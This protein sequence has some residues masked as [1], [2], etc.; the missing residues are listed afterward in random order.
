[1]RS[2]LAMTAQRLAKRMLGIPA[3]LMTAMFLVAAPAAAAPT[4]TMAAASASDAF[5]IVAPD[6]GQQDRTALGEAD[7]NFRQ[8]FA[9]WGGATPQSGQAQV[10]IPSLK[11]VDMMRFTSR[12]G[13][14]TD[15]FQG[16]RANHKGLDIAG[17]IGTPIHATAD[18]IVGRAQWVNGYGKFVEINHGGEIQTRYGHM[19]A[20]NVTPNQRV[21]KGDII[22]Y[23]GSTGRSTGSHLHYEVRLA[24]E[25]INPMGFLPVDM[26]NAQNTLIAS[27][28]GAM[29]EA[30]DGSGD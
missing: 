19:S 13:Y 9:R 5:R 1:M 21:H 16:R 23:M 20:L 12:F 10:A 18:G 4:G 2:T 6:H 8:L 14:R 3:A 27:A 17:P 15:P 29:D 24:G 30:E 11:P 26:S 22:G 7:G 28:S 25:P